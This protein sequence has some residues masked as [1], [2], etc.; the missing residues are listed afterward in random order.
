MDEMP[1]LLT[2]NIISMDDRF[3]YVSLWFHGEVRQYNIEDRNKLKLVG[4]V[5]ALLFFLI[6]ACHARSPVN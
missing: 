6:C 1:G 4:K 2:D 3:M 5:S